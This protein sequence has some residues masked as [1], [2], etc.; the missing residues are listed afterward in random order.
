MKSSDLICSR[1]A[2]ENSIKIWL[3]FW[4]WPAA[5]YRWW[6]IWWIKL[7]I[8]AVPNHD[9]CRCRWRCHIR[10]LLT[11]VPED[12][13]DDHWWRISPFYM[14]TV[15]TSI[16]GQRSLLNW[17]KKTGLCQVAA[18]SDWYEESNTW[19]NRKTG[20]DI[21][22][23][24]MCRYRSMFIGEMKTCMGSPALGNNYGSR[25]SNIPQVTVMQ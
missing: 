10:T 25:H 14:P 12:T 9:R 22:R 5:W 2:S 18:F 21:L 23:I 20:N 7:D 8:T 1:Y 4:L 3:Q 16:Q 24:F 6:W 15:A 11:F 17:S 19:W 13:W